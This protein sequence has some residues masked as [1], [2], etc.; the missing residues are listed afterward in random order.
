M[1]TQGQ[2]SLSQRAVLI[3]Q[4]LPAG[5][6]DPNPRKACRRSR[7]AL[8]LDVDQQLPEVAGRHHD[9]GVELDDVALVQRD[10]VVRRQA[11]PTEHSHHTLPG[12]GHF[13]SLETLIFKN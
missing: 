6:P 2:A 5:T 1:K 11:L 13:F 3:P 10:V 9:G 8:H 12:G 7:A 4:E